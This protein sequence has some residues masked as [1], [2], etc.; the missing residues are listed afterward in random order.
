VRAVDKLGG[1]HP[2]TEL[3]GYDEFLKTLVSTVKVGGSVE[4]V[5]LAH[6]AGRV[7][8]SDVLATVDV[9]N[10]RRA[11]FDGYAVRSADTQGA[12]RDSPVKLRLVGVSKPGN[13]KNSRVAQGEAVKI[14]TGGAVPEGADAV[15]M[16]ESTE[17]SGS[18]VYVFSGVRP[19]SCVDDAGSDI[20]KGQL[21]VKAS[22]T[23]KPTDLPILASQGYASLRVR[24]RPRVFI[25]P[26][27]NE[28]KPLGSKLREG[29]IYDSNS[30][31]VAA[32]LTGF[33]ARVTLSKP[34]KD[35]LRRVA[36]ALRRSAGFDLT[37]FIG[38]SSAGAEDYVAQAVGNQGKVLVHGLALSP[39]R[40]TLLGQTKHA[41]VVGLPGHPASSMAVSFMVLRPLISVL[42]GRPVDTVKVE[43]TL[44]SQ[45]EEA[46]P[47]FTYFR[48]VRLDDGKAV[49]A[50]KTSSAVSSFLGADGYIVFK[51]SSKPRK[52]EKVWVNLL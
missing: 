3:M 6:A 8:A 30:I 19:G 11:A 37:V 29:E 49:V 4:T 44:G 9:P 43:A 13:A 51:G 21:L 7:S 35:D 2:V 18:E 25:V 50:Y 28:I 42:L 24:S 23:I 36:S 33:G 46:K 32:L 34:V 47:N 40:P 38:G 45:L 17:L 39:G 5:K 52:G 15:V 41:F 48:T 1:M 16:V 20:K 22:S 26:T 10:F 14:F 12:T 31:G 27:G